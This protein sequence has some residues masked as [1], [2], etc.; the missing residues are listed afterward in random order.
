[1]I[2][3]FI[4]ITIISGAYLNLFV[5]MNAL[6]T[7]QYQLRLSCITNF[8]PANPIAVFANIIDIV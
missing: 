6:A 3:R 8:A 1:M 4:L 7:S 2:H 5:R